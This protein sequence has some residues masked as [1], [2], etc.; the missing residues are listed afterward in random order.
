ML[1][2]YKNVHDLFWKNKSSKH[3]HEYEK[4]SCFWKKLMIVLKHN[5][6]EIF[7]LDLI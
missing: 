5:K 2:I 1:A 6:F 7:L 4:C 3:I